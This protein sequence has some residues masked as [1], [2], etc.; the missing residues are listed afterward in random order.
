MI[1]RERDT[2]TGWMITRGDWDFH[3][4][5]DLYLPV[6]EQIIEETDTPFAPW[7]IVEATNP[8]YAG[9]K[10][11]SRITKALEKTGFRE[12]APW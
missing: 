2:L 7:T 1:E 10:V 12:R 6:I 11:I 8:A 4:H 3:H 9:F 5:Y